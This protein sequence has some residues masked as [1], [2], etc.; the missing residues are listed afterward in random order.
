[1]DLGNCGYLS[2]ASL[3]SQEIFLFFQI[4]D[5]DVTLASIGA[6]LAGD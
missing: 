1:V 6:P 5:L 3:K 4:D 2:T